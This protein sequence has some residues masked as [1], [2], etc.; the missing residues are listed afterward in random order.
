MITLLYHLFSR[1]IVPLYDRTVSVIHVKFGKLV[2]QS[3]IDGSTQYY[4]SQASVMSA[5]LLL[6]SGL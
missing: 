3:L 4:L 5:F 1:A 2:F 6:K